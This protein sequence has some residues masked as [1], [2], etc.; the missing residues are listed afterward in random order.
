M[1]DCV[2]PELYI[3]TKKRPSLFS[4]LG[5]R[6]FHARYRRWTGERRVR[7]LCIAYDVRCSLCGME[8][9]ERVWFV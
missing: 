4:Y 7:R 1:R 9:V 6:W 3:R 5:C 8:D 2:R